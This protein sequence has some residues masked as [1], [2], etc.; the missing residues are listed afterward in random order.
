[1]QALFDGLTPEVADWLV[2]QVPPEMAVADI[3]RTIINDA[4]HDD[5]EE[6][7]KADNAN[8]SPDKIPYA[9]QERHR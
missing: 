3:I 1:M 6:Q 2:D 4:F 7:A 9:G 8:H 5:Q